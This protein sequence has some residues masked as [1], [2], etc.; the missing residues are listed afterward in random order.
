MPPIIR[1]IAPKGSLTV[2]EEAW[3]AYPYCRT[4]LT[5]PD[6]MK[7]DF[8]VKIETI[9]LPDRGT[10]EN[11]FFLIYLISKVVMVREWGKP[12]NKKCCIF[13]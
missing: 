10:T 12:V 8:Y 7:D 13:G 3:N 1:K 11:V 4:I 5:N 9:H 2:C 6:F